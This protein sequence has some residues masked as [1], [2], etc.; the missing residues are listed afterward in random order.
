MHI[1]PAPVFTLPPA[2]KR[3]WRLAA[4][5]AA[6]GVAYWLLCYP[7]LRSNTLQV[8][9]LFAILF[10]FYGGIYLLVQTPAQYRLAWAAAWGYRALLLFS[11][12]NLS[13]D[14]YRFMWDGRLLL[15]GINPFAALPID[16]VN[17]TLAAPPGI[18]CALYEQLNS[19]L[20]Y[21][22]YP[23][24]C[25]VVFYLAALLFPASTGGAVAVMKSCLLLFET[26]T[27][28][29][30]PQ[31]LKNLRL[32]EKR[33]LLYALNPLAI[34]EISGN[35][36]FEG[37]LIFFLLAWVY[38]LSVCNKPVESGLFWGL[39]VC[40]KL[41]PLLFLLFLPRRIGFKKTAWFAMLATL[42][43]AACFLPFFEPQTAVALF[44]S[45]RLY[46]G[47][48][49]FN[50]GI[51]YLLRAMG[52]VFTG[53]NTIQTTGK[54]LAAVTFAAIVALAFSEKKVSAKTLPKTLLFALFLYFAL[55]TTV[56][57]WYL[58][59][60]VALCVFTPY[61]FA[62]VWSGVALLSYAAY[63]TTAY[64]ENL[65]LIA[66]EYVLLYVVLGRELWREM[67]ICCTTNINKPF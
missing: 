41:L 8:W 60:L 28:L 37:A 67:K 4:L 44:S 33:T 61:R 32:P 17:Q 30:M 63:H 23:P 52:Y 54:L 48:F 10:A 7:T 55:S 6:S 39:A 14:F 51:Y 40:S 62:I 29:L 22:V 27:L 18:D 53:Y 43:I 59:T 66:I 34:A 13:D 50:A 3:F 9:V 65:W 19:P 16:Y 5:L 1:L 64:T 35:L 36:H 49:E 31:L 25:Q 57:P 46:F 56:H 58:T 20:Y 42:V 47:R 45:T 26:G 15:H 11:L 24:V 21:T 38:C 12:P 2:P